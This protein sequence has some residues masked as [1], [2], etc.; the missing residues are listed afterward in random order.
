LDKFRCEREWQLLKLLL[1]FIWSSWGLAMH[2][3]SINSRT[4]NK[5]KIP[6]EKEIFFEKFR[7]E[8]LASLAFLTFSESIEMN[9]KK[10]RTQ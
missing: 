9:K 5:Q 1:G 10:K 8:T 7:N 2:D 6:K 4:K 3:W